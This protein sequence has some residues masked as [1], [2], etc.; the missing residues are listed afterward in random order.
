MRAHHAFFIHCFEPTTMR[1]GLLCNLRLIIDIYLDSFA[2][3]GKHFRSKTGPF[4]AAAFRTFPS[5]RI[6]IGRSKN[7]CNIYFAV[8]SS[9][10]TSVMTQFQLFPGVV[11]LCS[12]PFN[13]ITGSQDC[14]WQHQRWLVHRSCIPSIFTALLHPSPTVS[15]FRPHYGLSPF[16]PRRAIGWGNG[17]L[18]HVWRHS[19]PLEFFCRFLDYECYRAD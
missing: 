16:H 2:S 13:I 7:R 9:S 19:P 5:L 17:N 6:W 10:G 12:D 11:T 8:L 14:K 3:L 18:C 15:R 4:I 1:A